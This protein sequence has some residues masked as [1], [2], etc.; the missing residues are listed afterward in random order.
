MKL[1]T[2]FI[3]LGLSNQLQAQGNPEI[4]LADISFSDE[5]FTISNLTN[6][7]NSPGYDNQPSFLP[8]GSGVLF[9]SD[10]GESTDIK[11]Y[12]IESK[13]SSWLTNSEGGKYSP[14][15]TPDRNFF[16]SIWLKPDGE[17]LLWKYSL[18]GGEPEVIVPNEVIGY[19]SWFDEQTLYTFV[20][21]D[22]ATFVEF[23]LGDRIS[24][25]VIATSPGR[26]IHKIPGKEE[27]SFIDK[28]EADNWI[29]KSYDPDSKKI[30]VFTSTPEN[31][32]DMYW[33]NSSSFLIGNGNS[34]MLWKEGHGYTNPIQIFENEGV[35]SRISIS[36]DRTKVAIV[37]STSM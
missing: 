11:L 36:P 16:S 25:K 12:S 35:I 30:K 32:E 5:S 15:V 20:L 6:I 21:G 24:R 26:S 9:T 33:V 34:L 7:S 29:I 19:H 3:L 31:S 10:R 17:Q 4:Y 8:D 22:N 1:L 2:L 13:T 18:S 28:N 23:K 27:I 14:T 37:F